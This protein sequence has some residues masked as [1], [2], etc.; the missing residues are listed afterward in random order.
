M[1]LIT[2]EMH[3]GTSTPARNRA[4]SDGIHAAMV[5][6]LGIPADDRFHVVH[7]L[8]PGSMFHDDVVF[9]RPRTDR[10]MFI[11]LS[12]NQ[13]SPR[14]KDDLYAAL[15]REIGARTDVTEDDL[16]LRVLETASE[17]WWAAGRTV[18]AATGYDA[19]MQV[20]ASGQLAAGGPG[21]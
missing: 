6:V 14:Q 17:N 3:A 2:I 21:R 18:D 16:L 5:E 10:L 9:G 8:P 11:T 1:P 12:F 20:D 13:R 4:I 15:V 7:E 19:R